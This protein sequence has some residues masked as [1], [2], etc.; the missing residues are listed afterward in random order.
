MRITSPDQIVAAA[1]LKPT[2]LDKQIIQNIFLPSSTNI[3]ICHFI[4][5]CHF[6]TLM[7]TRSIFLCRCD[8]FEDIADGLLPPK[9]KSEESPTM[10][11]LYEE[12][13]RIRLGGKR[14]TIHFERDP[15]QEYRQQEIAR[16]VAY[17]H[18]WFT[19]DSADEAMW[20]KYGNDGTGVCIE[21][22]S[23]SLLRSMSQPSTVARIT[24]GGVTY[25]DGTRP[26][27]TAVSYAPF[28]HKHE[29]FIKEQEIRVVAYLTYNPKTFLYN[30]T[31]ERLA[32]PVALPT[33]FHRIIFGKHID[34]VTEVE[35]TRL[36]TGS[37]NNTPIARQIG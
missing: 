30:N 33:L 6:R 24:C 19:G 31:S 35:L 2:P 12:L 17:V 22:S 29:Q 32:V 15:S 5:V 14:R 23:F 34:R 4:P 10:T 27:A 36:I 8:K 21:S 25:S 18:C 26:I 16:T 9:N 37:A 20:K 7:T 28:F 3:R 11:R 13:G 1:I